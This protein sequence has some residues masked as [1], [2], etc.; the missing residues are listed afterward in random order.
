MPL[1]QALQVALAAMAGLRLP[2]QTRLVPRVIM[3]KCH[4]A[5]SEAA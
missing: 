5:A 1:L 3:M 4:Q 2:S